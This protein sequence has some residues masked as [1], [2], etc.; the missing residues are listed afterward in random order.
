MKKSAWVSY[1]FKEALD[2]SS[3]FIDQYVFDVIIL[4]CENLFSIGKFNSE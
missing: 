4:L 1:G 2:Y 3:V